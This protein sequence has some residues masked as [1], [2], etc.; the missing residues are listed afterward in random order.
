M[1]ARLGGD[2]FAV[3]LSPVRRQADVTRIA[4]KIIGS[5]AQPVP[6][7]N[8]EQVIASLSI[9]IAFYPDHAAT[10]QGLLHE[11]DDAMY[12]AKHR[13]HGGWRLATQK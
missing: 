2:E 4:D 1:V 9:G 12:Q 7:P 8:Q 11:A 3:L 10:P 6:L 13:Y 5:M